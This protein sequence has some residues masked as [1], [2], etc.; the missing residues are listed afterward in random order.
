LLDLGKDAANALE[1]SISAI[2][3]TAFENLMGQLDAEKDAVQ[4]RYD[5]E[6]K[7][8]KSQLESQLI[9]QEEYERK[10]ENIKKKKIQRENAIDKKIFEAEKKRDKQNAALEVA[11]AI[12]SL[13][14]NNFKKFDTTAALVLTAIG[15]SIAGAQYAAQVSAINQRQFFPTRFA[16]GGIVNGPSHAEGGVPFTVKGQSGYEM[17]GGEFIVNKEATKR[18]YSLLKKINDSVKPSKYS[19]GKMFASGG[20]VKAEEV[21]MRQ[22]ELL[23]TI[24]S[25]TGGTYINT[26]KPVRAFVSSDDLRKSDVDLRIKQRNSNL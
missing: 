1:Q 9:T 3:D 7:V 5:F 16:D 11:E 20:L 23:E 26:A 17:E 13:A 2:R 21:G 8:L 19:T 12:A 10:L 4:E 15:A 6:D 22:I 25:A 14:I 24:A 18:N